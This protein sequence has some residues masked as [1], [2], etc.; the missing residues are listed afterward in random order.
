MEN[1]EGHS[2][3]SS[4]W[5]TFKKSNVPITEGHPEYKKAEM[6]EDEDLGATIQG[7]FPFKLEE[8][9]QCAKGRDKREWYIQFR[10]TG[11]FDGKTRRTIDNISGDDFDYVIRNTAK[12][13]RDSKQF[14][15]C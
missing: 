8:R 4:P 12:T 6:V 14:P 7:Y 3:R 13:N 9:Y 15:F 5:V 10:K 1:D 2:R 11:T